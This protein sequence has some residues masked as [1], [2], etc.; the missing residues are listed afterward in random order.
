MPDVLASKNSD[1]AY[2]HEDRGF[3]SLTR[4]FT[5][6]KSV[7]SNCTNLSRCSLNSCAGVGGG[8]K[9]RGENHPDVR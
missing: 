8:G 4:I 3:A 7:L 9:R 1:S 2:Q 5:D 6:W